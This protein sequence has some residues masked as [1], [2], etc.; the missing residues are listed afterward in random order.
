MLLTPLTSLA[1]SSDTWSVNYAKNV[2]SAE[3]N[4]TDYCT[5]GYYS[6]GYK[7]TCSKLTGSTDRMIKITSSNAGGMKA[8]TMTTTGTS[9][10]WKMKGSTTGNVKFTVTAYGNLSCYSTG[11]IKCAY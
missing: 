8:V 7:A 1:A 9:S 3:L 4:K 10:I 5:L 2:P 11:T 6:D